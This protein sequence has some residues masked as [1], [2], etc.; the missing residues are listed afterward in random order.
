MAFEEVGG[1]RSHSLR[2]PREERGDRGSGPECRS[3]AGALAAS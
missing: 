3:Q 1:G 2:G